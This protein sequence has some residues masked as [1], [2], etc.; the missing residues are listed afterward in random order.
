MSAEKIQSQ[1]TL[2][3]QARR[4]GEDSLYHL[5]SAWDLATALGPQH[6]LFVQVAYKRAKALFMSNALPQ[7]LAALEPLI[8]NKLS[9]LE[10]YPLSHRGLRTLT[11]E[12]QNAHGYGNPVVTQLFTALQYELREHHKSS[13]WADL[14]LEISWDAL[15]RGDLNTLTENSSILSKL[16]HVDDSLPTNLLQVRVSAITLHHANWTMNKDRAIPAAKELIDASEDLGRFTA[17]TMVA[18]LE[19]QVRF[20]LSAPTYTIEGTPFQQEYGEALQRNKGYEEA[21]LQ[22]NEEGPEWLLATWQS[23][24]QRS[25]QLPR[26]IHPQKYGCTVFL[27]AEPT[28]EILP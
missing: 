27:P 11:R 12:Y 21:T 19:C 25:P 9:L 1:L 28:E 10:D 14:L 15:C 4:R 8:A 24:S 26:P 3:R 16:R 17:G 5:E 18:L 13:L 23:A 2:A 6:P 20:G 22:A 7:A